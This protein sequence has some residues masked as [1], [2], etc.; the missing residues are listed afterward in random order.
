[1]IPQKIHF[2]WFSDEPYP[3]KIKHCI[4][5]W[6]NVM[7]EYEF[8]HWDMDKIS[9]IDSEFLKEAIAEKKWAFA[10][11]FVRIW[12]LYYEGGIYLDT[13]VFCYKSFDDL[14]ENKCFIGKEMSV[15]INGRMTEQYLTSHCMGAERNHPFFKKCLDYYNYRHFITSVDRTL[16][17]TLRLSMTLL[18]YIQCEIAKM[19][20]YCPYPSHTSVQLLNDGLTIYPSEY[21]D[22]VEQI[23]SSYCKHLALG[24]W[25]ESRSKNEKITLKYKIRWRIEYVIQRLLD[26]CGYIMT[27]KL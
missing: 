14:L 5:S 9:T 11:D 15:H 18:P 23:S 25:R 8:I 19:W 20:N 4:E 22:C 12:A 10:A 16:P 26:R 13:D 7:S 1:M 6:H 17:A 24:S 27:K 21:F 3:E 2:T